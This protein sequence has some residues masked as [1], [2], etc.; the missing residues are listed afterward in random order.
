MAV[1]LTSAIAIIIPRPLSHAVAHCG[2]GG[3]AA[4]I[5]L[6]LV[7][8]ERRA[9]PWDVR[10]DEGRARACVRMLT[11]PEA[12]LA[13]LPRHHTDD[14]GTIVGVGAVA[15]A[16]IGAATG[17]VGGVAMR[18]AVVPPRAET[19]H[20]PHTSRQS[21]VSSV[22]SGS[23]GLAPAGVTSA[24]ACVTTPTRGPRAPLVRPWLSREAAAPG[25][26]VVAA[27][28]RTRSRSAAC[29][30]R[31]NPD[32]GRPEN[33][34][35]HGR[36]AVLGCHRE[37]MRTHPDGGG[38]R[39]RAHTCCRPCVRLS[40]SLS[41]NHVTMLSTVATHEPTTFINTGVCSLVRRWR[42][43]KRGRSAFL[44]LG[45]IVTG[46]SLSPLSS[47]TQLKTL[48]QRILSNG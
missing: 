35:V 16:L 9:P 44:V 13:R 22:R 38:V 19:A 32:S 37:D 24:L 8:L 4:P 20:P 11:P 3:M 30:T 36:H 5:A 26:L 39:A 42:H 7:G 1:H 45:S 33:A 23:G 15:L 34:V 40:G 31:H 27:S 21:S 18:P 43:T 48:C 2:M 28:S 17:R 12:G 10:R 25:W 46:S 6:P 29:R 41:W 47:S 14:G